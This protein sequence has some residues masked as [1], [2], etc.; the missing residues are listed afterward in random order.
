MTEKIFKALDRNKDGTLNLDEFV[1]GAK[2]D[3]TLI[4]LLSGEQ[5]CMKAL[6]V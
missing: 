4:T 5:K 3:A 1:Q 6:A 2:K